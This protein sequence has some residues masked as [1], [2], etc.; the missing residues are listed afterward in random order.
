MAD[1]CPPGFT[2]YTLGT[3]AEKG[4]LRFYGRILAQAER[5]EDSVTRRYVLYETSDNQFVGEATVVDND[6]AG[7][8][9]PM[10]FETLDRACSWFL[11]ETLRAEL[12]RQLAEPKSKSVK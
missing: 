6:C 1:Q 7:F 12:L 10:L 3:S 5:A 8:S 9:I 11:D 2:E 4:P